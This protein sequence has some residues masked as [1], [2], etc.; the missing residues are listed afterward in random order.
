MANSFRDPPVVNM[1]LKPIGIMLQFMPPRTGFLGHSWLTKQPEH[2]MA[3]RESY[4]NPT[5]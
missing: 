1:N 5:T 4:S 2:S 3:D